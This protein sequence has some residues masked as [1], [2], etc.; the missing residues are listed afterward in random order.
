M[1]YRSIGK[2]GMSASIIGLGTE[3]LDRKPYQLCQEV[4]DAALEAGINIMDLFM[5]GTAVRE[6]IGRALK[7]RRTKVLIQGHIGSVEKNGQY[8]RT[9]DVA[10]CRQYFENLLRSLNTDYIDFGMMYFVDTEEDYKGVFETEYIDYVL[11]LKEEGKIRAIGVSSHNPKTAAKVVETGLIDLLMFALNPAYDMLSADIS[12]EDAME[13]KLDPSQ[14]ETIN[15][16]RYYLYKL[17][18]SRGVAITTMK[19]LGA[20]KLLSP[21]FSPFQKPLTAAQ[22]IHY[23]LTRPAVVS[24]LI[25]CSTKEHVLE[26]VSYL[27]LSDEAK[28]FSEIIKAGRG[29]LS[30][31]CMYCNHCLPCPAEIDIAATLRLLD[32]ALLD[33]SS[34]SEGVRQQY[35]DLQ[36]TAAACIECGNCEERCPFD[37]PVIEHM[38]RAVELFGN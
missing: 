26:A 34:I 33:A 28:D 5:P 38:H 37:V 8:H 1:L 12:L 36:H 20:G 3:H 32:I 21:D 15:P 25:G 29:S 2:T 18:E 14:Y 7:G 16:D 23:A 24:T 4:I 10:V 19:T 30:G 6:N 13:G 17:C 22:C 35:N 11:K 27:S 9:R 31:Q